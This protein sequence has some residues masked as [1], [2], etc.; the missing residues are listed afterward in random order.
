M[1]D[2]DAVLDALM[3]GLSIEAAA[4]RFGM[5]EA[6]VREI[7]K[8]EIDRN[9]DGAEMRAEWTLTARRLRRM[10]LAF[11]RKAIADHDCA[12]A[13]VSI[14]ASER[15]ATLMGANAPPAQLV[16]VM[17]ANAIAAQP[18]STEQINRLVDELMSK[19]QPDKPERPD[20]PK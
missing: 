18:S 8:A 13:I 3:G 16:T 6:D 10:E 15:R 4:A 14:K 1:L 7:L 19:A 2:R 9:H 17:H 11:D 5:R 12:A 20:E